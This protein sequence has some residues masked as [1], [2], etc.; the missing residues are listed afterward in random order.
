M[1]TNATAA[2]A[3]DTRLRVP[4]A[5]TVPVGPVATRPW[6][7]EVAT[8]H[9]K[10]LVGFAGVLCSALGTAA[11]DGGLTTSEVLLAVATA[12]G[13]GLGV[14]RVPNTGP[15]AG[16]APVPQPVGEPAVAGAGR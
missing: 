14:T 11:V 3:A 12:L 5:R 7:A 6:W 9:A 4:A 16:G 2:A 13:V 15:R 10:A 8:G 1:P